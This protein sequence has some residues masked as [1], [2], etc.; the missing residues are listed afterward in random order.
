MPVPGFLT[1]FADK[2][3]NALNQSPI[4]QHIP[5]S[6]TGSSPQA[7]SHGA[8][9]TSTDRNYTLEQIQHQF[10]QLQQNYSTTSPLQK[11]IT[12]EKGVA[13]DYATLSRDAQ[14]QSKELYLWGQQEQPDVKDVSDRL[15]FLN[16]I[17][18]SLATTLSQK[19]V[20]A[21]LPLKELRDNDAAFVQRHSIR[22]GLEQ[23]ISR[24]DNSREKGYEKRLAEL[25]EQLAKAKSDDEPAD[26]QHDILLRKAL[27]ESEQGKFQALREYGEKLALVAQAAESVLAVLPSIPPS[28]SQPYKAVEE[29][30][31]IRASLQHALDN[32][33]PGQTTLSAPADVILDRSNTGSFGETHSE[34][35]QQIVTPEHQDIS[36]PVREGTAGSSGP[37]SS[38]P[39]RPVQVPAPVPTQESGPASSPPSS[40]L[41]TQSVSVSSPLAASSTTSPGIDTTV[42]NN[43]PAPIPSASPPTAVNLSELSESVD[44]KGK[45]PA[46]T[47]SVAETGVPVSGGPGGPGPS[48]GSLH[49]IRSSS[50]GSTQAAS[51]VAIAPGT[52]GSSTKQ[53]ESA[54]EEKRRL[55]REERE[56]LL[57]GERA[58]AESSDPRDDAPADDGDTPP[59][60]QDI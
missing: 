28:S 44:G 32:W 27:R 38:P 30:G 12:A 49:E 19:L 60:Y 10:R 6:L 46:V 9:S 20:T 26:K 25:Q 5:A 59:P 1:S 52:E 11:I 3:Q 57:Q 37:D 7:P 8:P 18:A 47:P 39:S 23:Q 16:Y 13:L 14:S 56:R 45:V 21:R 41:R 24:V 58:S 35:L 55:A 22:T 4:S 53:Y 54:E 50:L 48:S 43:E 17:A 33:K 51:D 40:T 42:L 31:S 36:Q 29:T 2:A 15:G 34:E